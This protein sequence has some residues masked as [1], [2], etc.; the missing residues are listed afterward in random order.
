MDQWHLIQSMHFKKYY[1]DKNLH[2]QTPLTKLPKDFKVHEILPT[3]SYSIYFQW[4]ICIFKNY[5]TNT[6]NC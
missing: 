1:V 4:S 6:K 2:L 5:C 3:K